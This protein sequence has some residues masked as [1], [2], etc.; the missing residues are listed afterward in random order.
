MKILLVQLAFLGDVVLSTPLISGLKQIYPDS[1]LWVLT[2]PQAAALLERDPLI[3]GVLC[4]DKRGKNSGLRGLKAYARELANH[5]FDAAYSLHRSLRTSSLLL[6]AGIE[7]R[8]GFQESRA[9]W[10]YTVRVPRADYRHFHDVLRNLSLL[11]IHRALPEFDS[12]LRIF[13]VPVEK[14]SERVQELLRRHVAPIAVFPGSSWYTKQWYWEN[15]RDCIYEL[16]KQNHSIFLLGAESDR[17]ICEEIA[18][19]FKD[20]PGVQQLAGHLSLDETMTL[21][22]QSKLVI[23]NDSMA[24]HLASALAIPNV[25][26]YCATSPAFGFTPWHNKAMIVERED[27]DCKPCSRHG[28]M[29]CPTGTQACFR[30]L[31]AR[32]VIEAAQELM[33]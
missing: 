17:K 26:I 28:S 16:R 19:S 14:S 33:P 8:V 13:P 25:V 27:L 5:K 29:S 32:V 23:S 7:R 18:Q 15:F 4:F 24:V 20:D 30:K 12:R 6:L 10:M 11:S 21:V 3:Q 9:S 1:E 31:E 2:T 22:S